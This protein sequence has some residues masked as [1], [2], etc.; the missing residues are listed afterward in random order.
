MCGS[1]LAFYMNTENFN[2]GSPIC[3]ASVL[4]TEPLFQLMKVY[5][6]IVIDMAIKTQSAVFLVYPVSKI[7]ISCRNLLACVRPWTL[8]QLNAPNQPLHKQ[9]KDPI[10]SL[11]L[12]AQT[13]D[14]NYLGGEGKSRQVQGQREQPMININNI[15]FLF[16]IFLET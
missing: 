1:I 3:L 14:S 9:N 7:E 16:K 10:Y 15:K 8:P 4:P 2:S 13:C 5:T 6:V 11:G 12:V